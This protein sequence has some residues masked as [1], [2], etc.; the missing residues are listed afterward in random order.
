M[1]NIKVFTT[2]E[3]IYQLTGITPNEHDNALWDA[4]F[5]LDDW[6]FGICI[7]H[8]LTKKIYRKVHYGSYSYWDC[9]KKER[10]IVPDH[11]SEEE[12]EEV[13]DGLPFFEE[14]I[15]NDWANY[16]VGGSHTEYNGLHYYL[17]HHS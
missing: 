11:Y 4:G 6:D 16:C 2:R 17:W 1:V 8:P 5:N 9:I 13:L 12:E 7:D 10:V 15:F 14:R 3:E